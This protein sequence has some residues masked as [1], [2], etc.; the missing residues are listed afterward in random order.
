MGTEKS[1]QS[2]RG[3][4]KLTRATGVSGSGAVVH[5]KVAGVR[6]GANGSLVVQSLVLYY[7]GS[8]TPVVVPGVADF[9][10][11][12]EAFPE[13][14]LKLN[15]KV[16]AVLVDQYCSTASNGHN[17]T[18]IAGSSICQTSRFQAKRAAP[19]T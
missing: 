3:R 17:T 8:P 1:V 16:A 6:P 12:A 13:G 9:T 4:V 19:K 7:K 18:S 11:A 15:A 5:F 2:G 10:D 14:F